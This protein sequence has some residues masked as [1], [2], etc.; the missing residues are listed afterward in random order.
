MPEPSLPDWTTR[1]RAHAVSVC[2]VGP[3]GWGLGVDKWQK[4]SAQFRRKQIPPCVT[5]LKTV[6]AEFQTWKPPPREHPTPVLLLPR[7][8]WALQRAHEPYTAGAA[9]SEGW[10]LGPRPGCPCLSSAHHV[11]FSQTPS[12]SG[13]RTPTPHQ[14]LQISSA[15]SPLP[16]PCIVPRVTVFPPK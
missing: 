1:V 7:R 16:A 4:Y 5:A 12:F 13:L 2:V 11:S 10:V 9:V 14:P 6:S 15:P 8:A 3:V